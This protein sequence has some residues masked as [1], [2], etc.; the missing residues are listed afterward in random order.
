MHLVVASLQTMVV[1][2]EVVV[3]TG[4][5]Q[6]VV[7]LSETMVPSSEVMIV[8]MEA[9]AVTASGERSGAVGTGLAPAEMRRGKLLRCLQYARSHWSRVK[10]VRVLRDPHA[11]P[12][13]AAIA[14]GA[15]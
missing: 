6:V 3:V 12:P 4:L 7:A 2:L 8:R 1:W 15:W 5:M 11:Q 13:G 9:M 14:V 10:G